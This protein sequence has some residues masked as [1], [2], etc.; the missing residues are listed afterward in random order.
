MTHQFVFP[1]DLNPV[2]GNRMP[3]A[4]VPDDYTAESL[5][6]AA[7][8]DGIAFRKPGQMVFFLDGR[9]SAV[10]HLTDDETAWL[11]AGVLTPLQVASHHAASK[12]TRFTR[13]T[14][15]RTL[16]D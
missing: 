4:V 13:R 3:P 16:F 9:R 10:C 6:F 15:G 14:V 11:D 5:H 2:P 7:R 1:D 8:I 12:Y